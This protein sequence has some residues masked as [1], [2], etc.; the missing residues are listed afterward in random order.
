MLVILNKLGTIH[1]IRFSSVYN[2]AI[3]SC[4]HSESNGDTA[5][6]DGALSSAVNSRSQQILPES[7]I[8]TTTPLEQF[9]VVPEHSEPEPTPTTEIGLQV[10][11]KRT[12]RL[13]RSM[14]RRLRRALP[15]AELA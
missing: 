13:L 12:S 10:K 6:A 15:A 1:Y 7:T 5:N 2:L 14:P 3:V 11:P 9:T 8:L 4:S